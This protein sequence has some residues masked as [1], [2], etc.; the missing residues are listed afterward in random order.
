MTIFVSV[1][2]PVYRDWER[3]RLCLD[4]LERQTIGRDRFEV[5]VVNNEPAVSP[6][7]L[8]LA[9]NVSIIDEA[10]P[11]SYAARNTAVAA[12]RGELLAFVDSDCIPVD[13][14]LAIGVSVLAD[15]PEARVTGPVPIY[16]EANSGYLAYLYEFH[17]AFQFEQAARR[18]RGGA[19]NL[20][21]ARAVF[22]RVG[23]FD[24]K[25]GSGGDMEWGARAHDAGIPIVYDER[26]R[27]SHPARRSI[28]MIIRKRRRIAGS[29][30]RRKTFP[31]FWYVVFKLLPPVSS[32]NRVVY[33]AARGPVRRIDWIALFFV[34]WALRIAEAIEVFLVRLGLKSPNRT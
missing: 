7:P 16:R 5:I 3:L 1:I 33:A 9:A 8:D 27:V 14:W 34:H 19:G 25:L 22:D 21:V 30:A 6:P 17:T 29:A 10:F 18:G 15:N 11:G 12:S 2:I 20:M 28:A 4:A 24:P 13:D 26:F 31:T 32:Y 23:W